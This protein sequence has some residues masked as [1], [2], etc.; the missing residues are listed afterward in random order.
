MFPHTVRPTS[1]SG[2]LV[3]LTLILHIHGLA[4]G[5]GQIR[6]PLPIRFEL[7]AVRA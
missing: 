4:V 3:L 1:G 7:P 5:Y 2:P 6:V